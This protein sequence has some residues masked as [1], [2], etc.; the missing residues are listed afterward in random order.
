MKPTRANT[1]TALIGSI[2]TSQIVL[3]ALV[4]FKDIGQQ[5]GRVLSVV[6]PHMYLFLLLCA[7]TCV[8]LFRN[9]RI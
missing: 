6:S 8:N 3:T 1:L 2:A 4:L 9:H 5:Y 7:I